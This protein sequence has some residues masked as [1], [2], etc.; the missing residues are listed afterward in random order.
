MKIIFIS[1][2]NRDYFVSFVIIYRKMMWQWEWCI[3]CSS[4]VKILCLVL[5]VHLNLKT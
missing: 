5:L 2:F 3:G 1:Y 4:W